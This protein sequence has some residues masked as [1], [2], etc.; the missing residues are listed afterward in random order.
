MDS[1]RQFWNKLQQVLNAPLLTLGE[2]QLTPLKILY[3]ALLLTVLVYLSGKI[4]CWV[5]D[6]LLKRTHLDLGTRNAIGTITRYLVVILGLL[7][8]FQTVG[9]NLTTFSILTGAVGIGLGFGLQNIANNFISG[10]IILF[11]QPI[12]VGDRITVGTAEGRVTKIGPRST[13]VLT[14]DSTDIIIPNS[15]LITDNV[16]NLSHSSHYV[17]FH[18]PVTVAS[19]SD[20]ANVKELLLE[21]ARSNPNVLETPAPSVAFVRF[22]TDGFD[23]ELLVWTETMLHS[24]LPFFSELNFAIYEIF[25][26]HQIEMPN[27][28]R[29]IY[30]R[31]GLAS[32]GVQP[33]ADVTPAEAAV[34]PDKK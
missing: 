10:I 19:N 22:G 21:V 18:V 7:V 9:V 34:M 6:N 33:S 20:L 14:N 28:Q 31:G 27:P 2:A 25:R 4:K 1:I 16:V 5:R 23:F 30:I 29:D 11:E 15:K 13:T 24:K 26:T 32:L 12:K 3:V 8:I 17:R